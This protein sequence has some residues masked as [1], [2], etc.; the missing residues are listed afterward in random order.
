MIKNSGF[1]LI[2]LAVTLVIAGLLAA[3]ITGGMH[4][5]QAAK[6]DKLITE[7]TGYSTAVQNFRLKYNAW[8][9][10]MPNATTYW[11]LYNAGTNPEG[12]VN[13]D[14]NERI[15]AEASGNLLESLRAS[16]QMALG[17]FIAGHFTGVTNG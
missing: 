15:G 3:G 6:L 9:G 1:S 7:I 4:L 17:N 10:D 5:M 12:T 16:Q 14:G 2:E 13:G 11:G 8:P